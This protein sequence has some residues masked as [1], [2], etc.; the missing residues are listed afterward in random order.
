MKLANA[1]NQMHH[2][3]KIT[4]KVLFREI[5]ERWLLDNQLILKETTR[6]KYSHMLQKHIFPA[7]GDKKIAGISFEEITAFVF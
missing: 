6:N 4:K 5:A 2:E 3:N 1:K 7:F